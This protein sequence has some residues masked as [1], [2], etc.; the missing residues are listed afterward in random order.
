VAKRQFGVS[1]HLYRAQHLRRE[2]LLEIAAHGF[3]AVEVVAAPGHFDY[4]NP[5]AVADLQQ[6]LAEARLDLS[7]VALPATPVW[8]PADSEAPEEVRAVHIARRIPVKTLIVPIGPPREAS[9]L[10]E[11]LAEAAAPLGMTIAIDARSPSMTPIGSLVH[12]VEDGVDAR[13]GIAL[14]CATAVKTGELS[15]VIERVSEHLIAV[16]VPLESAVDWSTAMATLQKVGYEGALIFDLDAIG[17]LPREA[18]PTGM[19]KV[20]LARAK[21]AREKIERWLT[22]I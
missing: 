7:A 3:E 9:R 22:S 13:I 1:T 2:H 5:S 6:W 20:I 17:S 18:R 14:D 10:V 11:R 8:K 16:R 12:F 21:K 4:A 15:D 19:N